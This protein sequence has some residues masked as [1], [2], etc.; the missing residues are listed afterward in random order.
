MHPLRSLTIPFAALTGC[1]LWLSSLFAG[2]TANWMVLNRI[3]AGI[4]QSR[5]I[6]RFLGDGATLQMAHIVKQHLSGVAGYVCLGLL[7]GLLPFVG[8]FA[9]LPLEVRHITLASAS[10]TY[11][12]SSLAWRGAVPWPAVFWAIGGL[13]ATGL[14]NF[15]VSFTLGLWLALRARNLGTAGRKK[16][17]V[18]LWNEFRLHP[19]RFLWS[20][21]FA[22]EASEA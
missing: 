10:V 11:D 7:L 2:W 3:P 8:V 13:L 4:A 18:A 12:V 22:I 5:R 6:R 17:L 9:G 14:L 15:S 1:F 16:L 19:S 20:H 21:Q